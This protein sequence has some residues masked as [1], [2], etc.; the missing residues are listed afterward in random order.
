MG[1]ILLHKNILL[2]RLMDR[3]Q[4]MSVFYDTT[5]GSHGLT[6]GLVEIF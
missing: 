6:H 2:E 5:A 4:V 3:L 1:C